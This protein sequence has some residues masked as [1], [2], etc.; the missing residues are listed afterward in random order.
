MPTRGSR[1]AGLLSISIT[2]VLGSGFC[3]QAQR[4]Q[5]PAATHSH[6]EKI[7]D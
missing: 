4:S 2:S 6:R 5:S 3:E 7:V 1:F